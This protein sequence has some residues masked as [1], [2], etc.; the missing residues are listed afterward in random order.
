MKQEDN[1]WMTTMMKTLKV[2]GII[3]GSEDDGLDLRLEYWAS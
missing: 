2:D 1:R 3:D